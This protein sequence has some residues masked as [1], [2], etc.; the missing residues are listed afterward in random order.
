MRS[1]TAFHDRIHAYLPGWDV[2]KLDP[3]YFTNHF[4]FVSDF[5]AECWSQLRRTSR[6]DVIQHRLVWGDQLSGRDIKAANNTVNG[7]LKLLWPNHEIEVPDDA[8]AWA[9][10]VALELRRRVKEQQA[11][12][13]VAEFGKTDLSYRVADRPEKIVFCEESLDHHLRIESESVPTLGKRQ[14]DSEVLPEPDP[15]EV[16]ASVG[17]KAADY[18]VGDVIDGRFVILD[19][20]GQGGF[21]KVYRVR[22]EVEEEER[23]LKLFENAAGYQA[24]RREI[25]AL[26]K[27]HH[28]HVVQ[29]FWADKTDAGDWYLII[30]YIDGESLDEYASGKRHLRDREAVDVALDILDA[31][32]AIHPDSI[33]LEQLDHKKR[34]AE[35]SEI[36]YTEWMGLQDKG[37]VHRD[38]KP[39][40]V[41]LT[42]TGAKL[43]D[44]NIASRVGDPVYTQ[45]GTP[46]YQAPDANLTRWDVSTDLFA[47][48]VVLYQLLCN[49]HHPYPGSQPMAGESV[50]DPRTI[51][52]DLDPELATFLVK[53]CAP[54][55]NERF[56]TAQQMKDVLES[57]RRRDR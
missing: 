9:A 24:V 20:L 53:S 55:R 6:L 17:A 43:L 30:E 5:L 34:D 14:R 8:L 46:P 39:L 44:F 37:L 19:L 52:S 41:I 27:V 47:V 33:R 22:D 45:S 25:S 31:L 7:I 32:V 29:V 57:I 2:P 54:Y 35:L 48:G 36:E 11:A 38:I 40:N 23:A 42:R 50:T 18:V 1:D 28:P 15:A 13:G 26:R 4:G 10:E 16:K 56:T 21:S 3:S 49:G 51:R 12:I